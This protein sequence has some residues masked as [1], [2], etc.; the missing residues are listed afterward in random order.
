MVESISGLLNP[1]KVIFRVDIGVPYQ[2]DRFITTRPFELNGF[3]TSLRATGEHTR[4]TL[5]NLAEERKEHIIT[6]DRCTQRG[7]RQCTFGGSLT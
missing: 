6:S 3:F 1:D 2:A 4:I 5:H 7:S